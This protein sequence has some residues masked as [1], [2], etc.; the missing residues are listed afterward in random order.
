MSDNMVLRI[1]EVIQDQIRK[2]RTDD[3][4]E[5]LAR[6]DGLSSRLSTVDLAWRMEGARRQ[7]ELEDR[8]AI[9]EA[10]VEAL[11]AAGK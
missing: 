4:T 5:I 3:K 10:Q 1:L 7:A 8:I 2:I 6:I 11:K 9:L